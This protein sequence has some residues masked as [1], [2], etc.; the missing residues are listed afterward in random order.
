MLKM[1]RPIV[2]AYVIFEN[3]LIHLDRK[4]TLLWT[5]GF[6]FSFSS[7]KYRIL[8]FWKNKFLC[9]LSNILFIFLDWVKTQFS[10][11]LD[12]KKKLFWSGIV[13]QFECFSNSIWKHFLAFYCISCNFTLSLCIFY[14]RLKSRKLI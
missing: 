4:V 10:R 12:R 8:H 11:Q 13:M 3:Q 5:R 9:K 2:R 14:V 1:V 7:Y 6:R